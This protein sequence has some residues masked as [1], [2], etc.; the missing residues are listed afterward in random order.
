MQLRY[1]KQPID[2]SIDLPGSKSI[3][4]RLLIL[5]EVMNLGL[6]LKNLSTAKDTQD[7]LKILKDCHPVMDVG[8]AGTDMRFLTALFSTKPGEWTITGSDRMK[9]R[10]IKELVVALRSLGADI[11]YLETEG[12]P[13]LKII[14]KELTGG[15]IEIDGSISSQF[16]SALLLIAPGMKNGLEISVKN[17]IVS[18]SYI[19]MTIGL[20]KQFGVNVKSQENTIKV[21][22][23]ET[24]ISAEEFTIESDWSSAS[25]WYSLVALSKDA[26]IIL[27]G[28]Q[29]KSWQGDSVLPEIYDQLGVKSDP[30]AIRFKGD[31]L[32]LTKIPIAVSFFEYDFTDC[33]DIA[34]TVAVTC[35]GLNISCKLTGLSTLKHKETD[36]LAALKN[37]LE[38]FGAIVHITDST[39]TI[40]FKL[41]TIN[42]HQT[43]N[44]KLQTYNDH[45]MAMSF[46]P[47][48]LLFDIEIEDPGVVE[49]SYPEFWKH[50]SLTGINSK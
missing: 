14:G 29:E 48:A 35:L 31:A 5:N 43:P 33:P 18:R 3:S 32:I 11:S 6:N 4:N 17:T 8:H 39:I 38:K 47:L 27:K 20:L 25:Y 2:V 46:A 21:T 24:L 26:K 40:N 19:E 44:F 37:E 12:F 41:R 23:P 28:L 36:R 10:P 30:I 7:L 50:L 15:K 9:E 1:N 13:P 16:I 49:K 45:R 34:Q 42:L 22:P